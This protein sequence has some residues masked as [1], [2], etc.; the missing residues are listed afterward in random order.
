MLAGSILQHTC[1]DVGNAVHNYSLRHVD[2]IQIKPVLP[3]H[4]R[5]TE[6]D[7]QGQRA[8]CVGGGLVRLSQCATSFTQTRFLICGLHKPNRNK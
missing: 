3:K 5:Q 7:R 6:C 2:N 4:R 8:M 1:A